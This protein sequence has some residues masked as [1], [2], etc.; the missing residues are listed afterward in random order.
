MIKLMMRYI[1]L[2]GLSS[3]IL[4]CSEQK[5]ERYYQAHPDALEKAL[6]QCP[7][8]ALSDLSCQ[9]LEALANQL[10]KLAFEL[11]TSPQAYGQKILALQSL[12][13]K[14]ES[15]IKSDAAPAELREKLRENK[16]TLE[17]YLAVVRLLES[18][19]R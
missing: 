13:A 10:N 16:K 17:A 6:A 11:Q 5:D 7:H 18:P 4:A 19:T 8:K 2:L 15:K 14:Q 12:I 9:N 1:L 3:L